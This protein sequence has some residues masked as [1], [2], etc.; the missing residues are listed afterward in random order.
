MLICS[1]GDLKTLKPKHKSYS[2]N[3]S[4]LNPQRPNSETPG[5]SLEMSYSLNS[6]KGVI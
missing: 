3:P 2:L 6:L 4:P 5:S 1:G